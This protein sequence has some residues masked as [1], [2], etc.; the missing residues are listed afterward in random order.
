[1][2]D[3]EIALLLNLIKKVSLESVEFMLLLLKGK[4]LINKP[5]DLQKRFGGGQ[6]KISRE[7]QRKMLR[8]K[9]K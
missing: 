6:L 5:D 9:N 7:F 2:S 8:D 4:S 3:R 1:M